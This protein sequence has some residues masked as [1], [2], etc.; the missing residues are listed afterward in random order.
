MATLRF[1]FQETKYAAQYRELLAVYLSIKHFL[2]MVEGRR[3]SYTY[4]TSR[5]RLPFDRIQK[6]NYDNFDYISQFTKDI[7]HISRIG[8]VV[9]DAF[10]RID[11]VAV[12][13]DFEQLTQEHDA[14]LKNFFDPFSA[15]SLKHV[16]LLE[17]VTQLQYGFSTSVSRPFAAR[18]QEYSC[19]HL[20]NSNT[21][22]I[23]SSDLPIHRLTR[24]PEVFSGWI[25]WFGML[26]R[27]TTDEGHQ[28]EP[29]LFLE[30]NSPL[31]DN[32]QIGVYHPQANRM[33]QSFHRQLKALHC[34]E[35]QRCSQV[36]PTIL[37]SIRSAW[38]KDLGAT[39]VELVT[40]T[41][42]CRVLLQT[43]LRNC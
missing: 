16:K 36:L 9:V 28:F 14:E 6:N 25:L 8:N 30:L 34:P 35:T 33:V 10:S 22:H 19:Y 5:S 13:I 1:L 31:C 7:Q 20:R 4:T 32:S 29:N 38:K 27:L 24:Q 15:L 26:L 39:S 21:F 17:S 23:D 18:L 11:E 43:H 40:T 12:G 41:P 42:S 3:S 2:H 37:L